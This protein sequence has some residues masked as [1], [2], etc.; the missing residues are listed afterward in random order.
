MTPVTC[1]Y[2]PQCIPPGALCYGREGRG[3]GRWHDLPKVAQLVDDETAESRSPGCGRSTE[4]HRR[5][6]RDSGS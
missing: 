3:L 4:G 2:T 1:S 6:Q 5:G